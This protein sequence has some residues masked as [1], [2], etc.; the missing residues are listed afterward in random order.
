MS[1]LRHWL[2]FN[3]VG[4]I[5]IGVQLGA[6]TLAVGGLGMDYLPAT[7][8]A[9]EIAVLHNFVWHERWTWAERAAGRT[10]PTSLA[11]LL[12]FNLST[13]L[14][15]IGGNLLLM[16]LLV[17]SLGLHFLAANLATIT[18]CSIANF[19]ASDRLVF[20]PLPV[21]RADGPAS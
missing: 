3:A 9:V 18:A 8:L 12:R 19:L 17:G 5:G 16:R 11:R 4:A 7:A 21:V 14:I 13:G 6:L 15:S 20:T 2:K 1:L 10:W